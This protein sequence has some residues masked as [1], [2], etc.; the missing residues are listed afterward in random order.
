VPVTPELIEHGLIRRHAQ[1][2]RETWQCR[3]LAAAAIDGESVLPRDKLGM[4]IVSL[5]AHN[6][7][8]AMPVLL[9]ATF[10]AYKGLGFPALTTAA[11]IAKTGHVMAD[12][13]DTHGRRFKNQALFQNTTHMERDFR[14]LADRL[15][16]ADG[17]REELFAALRRWVVCDYRL[18]PLMDPK[19]PDARRLH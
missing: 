10:P 8:Q 14:L 13:I 18:D 3:V 17:D 5:L 11:K 6:F 15:K 19:D 2:L 16:L 12:L 1:E 4:C 7:D 9:L